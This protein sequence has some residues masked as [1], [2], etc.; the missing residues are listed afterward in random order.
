MVLVGGSVT[1]TQ[2]QVNYIHNYT[3]LYITI[4]TMTHSIPDGL[5]EVACTD[6]VPTSGQLEYH[7]SYHLDPYPIVL[8]SGPQSTT[9]LYLPNGLQTVL[10]TVSDSSGA[11]TT[12]QPIEI[13]V[14]SKQTVSSA[15]LTKLLNRNDFQLALQLINSDL[16]VYLFTVFIVFKVIINWKLDLVHLNQRFRGGYKRGMGRGAT[17]SIVRNVNR[18]IHLPDKC[19][20]DR[21]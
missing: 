19:S 16:Y 5:V 2:I 6:W 7:I 11:V 15:N 21:R 12:L 17:T 10:I 4:R 18:H 13:L 8:Y 14:D 9:S 3:I 20:T 1:S